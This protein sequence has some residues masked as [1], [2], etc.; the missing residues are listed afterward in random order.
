MKQA[1][2]RSVLAGVLVFIGLNFTSTHIVAQSN[3]YEGG[4]LHRSTVRTWKTSSDKNKL[5]TC[6]DFMAKVN[7]KI[8]MQELKIRSANLKTCIDEATRE[9]S[10]TDGIEVSSIASL[11]I[12]QLGYK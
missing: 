5:A 2:R 8:S 3:W 6:A 1:F 12:R 7:N 9:A 4:T 11:C 10:A